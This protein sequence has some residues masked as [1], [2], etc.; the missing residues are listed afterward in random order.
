MAVALMADVLLCM[1]CIRA[2]ALTSLSVK[3]ELFSRR[4]QWQ[5]IQ[6]P[7]VTMTPEGPRPIHQAV[8]VLR[9][10]RSRRRYGRE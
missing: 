6:P 9:R 1:L 7:K 3:Q 4:A 10:W 2:E 5:T 8:P